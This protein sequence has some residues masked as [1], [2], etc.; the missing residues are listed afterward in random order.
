MQRSLF[1]KDS[2]GASQRRHIKSRVRSQPTDEAPPFGTRFAI[3]P[4]SS[5]M[6]VQAQSLVT[7]TTGG[8]LILI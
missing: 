7:I 2:L 3:V 6:A 8:S 4:A 5:Q 1:P